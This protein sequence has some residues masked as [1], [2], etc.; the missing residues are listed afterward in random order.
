[1]Q[2]ESLWKLYRNTDSNVMFVATLKMLPLSL[3]IFHFVRYRFL[4]FETRQKY[5][6]L[7]P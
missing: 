7:G 3:M 4:S 6:V 2:E 5:H 1:M